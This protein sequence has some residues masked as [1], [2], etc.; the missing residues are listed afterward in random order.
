MSEN[1]TTR[2]PAAS[3]PENDAIGL[4]RKPDPVAGRPPIPPAED[5]RIAIAK[6]WSETARAAAR[7]A[8]EKAKAGGASRDEAIEAG[9]R[10]GLRRVEKEARLTPA[11]VEGLELVAH[12]KSLFGARVV[13]VLPKPKPLE[14]GDP[15]RLEDRCFEMLFPDQGFPEPAEPATAP[16]RIERDDEDEEAAPK[17]KPRE[18]LAGELA[19][20]PR[21]AGLFDRETRSA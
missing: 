7:A 21:Q 17:E 13:K 18:A 8:F 9:H 10:A 14:P 20:K 16:R 4:R 15:P 6:T 5:P 12:A 1:T 3:G 19:R 2:P 11:G